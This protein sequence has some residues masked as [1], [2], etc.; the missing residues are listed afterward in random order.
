MLKVHYLPPDD[1][2]IFGF[3]QFDQMRFNNVQEVR[4]TDEADFVVIPLAARS[5]YM[6]DADLRRIVSHWGLDPRRVTAYDCS[7]SDYTYP[8][9]PEAM[10]VRATTKT[11]MA[12]VNPRSIAWPWP[13]ED[14]SDVIPIPEG[15]FKYDVTGHMWVRYPTRAQACASVMK[16]FGDRAD[17]AAHDRF[18][19]HL[20]SEN[21]AIAVPRR[22][23]MKE[24][25][26]NS[27]ISLCPSS[28]DGD[29]PYRFF[30]ALSA[31]RVPALFATNQM[32]PWADRIDYSSFCAIFK[33]EDAKNAGP[34]IKEWLS[35]HTD[36]QIIEM[37]KRGRAAWEQWLDRRKF[38]DLKT[39]AIQESLQKAGL[40]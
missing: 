29:F 10:L 1:L 16:T 15:G 23:A 19:G 20:E 11:W 5:G 3:T 13:V 40:L 38:E 32:F 21:P 31:A 39:V 26:R 18:W 9:T 12:A 6:S 8:S 30:E 4:S 28:R 17:I 37:G 22:A 36:E 24:G 2:R 35:R 25:M 7:D 34:L 33:Q 14:W 27:R